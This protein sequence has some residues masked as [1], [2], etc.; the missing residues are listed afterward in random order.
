M[1]TFV[2]DT[3]VKLLG[4]GI[5]MPGYPVSTAQLLRSLEQ[6]CDRPSV[7]RARAIAHRLGI[8]HR[9]LSRD[10]SKPDAGLV[11]GMSAPELCRVA[12][13][14]ALQQS[15]RTIADVEYLV[16]HTTSPHT[17]LPPN[18]AWVAE[19]MDYQAP[20]ME[21]RQACT[22]FANALQIVSAMIQANGQ[23]CLAIVGSETGSAYF[24]AD[25]EFTITEQL[26]NYVQMGDGAGAVILGPDDGSGRGIISDLFVG[27]IGNGVSPGLA[28][29]GGGSSTPECNI[30]FPTFSHHADTVRKSGPRLFEMGVAAV[31]RRG[32]AIKDF[33]RIIPHQANGRIAAPLA[34]H[35]DVEVERIHVTAHRYGN[36][37]S[38]AIWVALDDLCHSGT[39]ASGDRVLVLGAEATKYLYG[40]F[41]YTH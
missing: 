33:K 36:L 17:L 28:I 2:A 11:A 19:E 34:A 1:S 25:E 41:V 18:I 20:Y 14:A 29:A 13:V 16:G 32:Y 35:L 21:L 31:Q 24:R 37:G 3:K 23:Q 15:G 27:H 9:H 4:S 30:G 26:V 40:G 39:L 38:A 6:F 22:G 5:G 12:L 10:L 8:E 7:R